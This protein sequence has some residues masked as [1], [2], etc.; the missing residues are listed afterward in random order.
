MPKQI[1]AVIL[2]RLATDTAWQGKGLGRLLLVDAVNRSLRA[3]HEISARLLIVHAISPAAEA[4][5]IRYGFSRLPVETP[6][7]AIDLVKFDRLASKE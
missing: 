2:G 7:Y 1:P 5:Y 4:F 6:T 3:S